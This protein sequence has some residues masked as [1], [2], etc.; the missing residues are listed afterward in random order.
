MTFGADLLD[1]RIEERAVNRVALGVILDAEAEGIIAQAHLL[2]D[3]VTG[4]PRLD[5]EPVA[6]LVDRLVVRA[7]DARE[8]GLAR[9]WRIAAPGRCRSWKFWP[10]IS[11]MSVPP[12]ATLSTW[13]PR[14]MA[15]TGCLFSKTRRRVSNSHAS[16][17][18]S[19]PSII[20]GSGT[21]CLRNS[22]EMSSP[23]VSS[24]PSVA[25]GTLRCAHST[26][27]GRDR[28]RTP[29]QSIG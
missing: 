19:A 27:V 28:G 18:G 25:S 15:K 10:G 21:G 20:L 14:Q 26:S 9:R 4:V 11:S 17:A 6:E 24:K 16:R 5:F 2:D 8:C 13:W 7:V 22:C 12:R 3:V 29:S 1:E 23:P